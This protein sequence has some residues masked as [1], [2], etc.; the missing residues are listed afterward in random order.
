MT[1]GVI[2]VTKID[3]LLLNIHGCLTQLFL[4]R[5]STHSLQCKHHLQSF[6]LGWSRCGNTLRL[7]LHIPNRVG[8]CRDR[9]IRRVQ[10]F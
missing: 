4:L 6:L 9:A 5:L 3:A 10:L 8:G 7:K 1:R 2:A